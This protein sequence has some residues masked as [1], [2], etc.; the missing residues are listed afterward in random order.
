MIY[1]SLMARGCA[2]LRAVSRPPT[3]LMFTVQNVEIFWK[4]TLWLCCSLSWRL[5]QSDG[6]TYRCS[7]WTPLILGQSNNGHYF[8]FHDQIVSFCKLQDFIG[9]AETALL[10]SQTEVIQ[11]KR[12]VRLVIRSEKDIMVYHLILPVLP[13]LMSK[14]T[15]ADLPYASATVIPNT[16]ITTH[17]FGAGTHSSFHI[18]I[19]KFYLSVL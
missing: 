5:W 12:L 7:S 9:E 14:P 10:F 13:D 3:L 16:D 1:S 6:K 4:R 17:Q 11:M 8:N 18:Y 15:P 19:T 2:N